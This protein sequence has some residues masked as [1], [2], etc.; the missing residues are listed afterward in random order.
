V[1]LEHFKDRNGLPSPFNINVFKWNNETVFT[2]NEGIFTYNTGKNRFEPHP[3]LTRTLG[4]QN[5]IRKLLEFRDM[6]WFVQDDE[7]GYFMTGSKDPVLT[8]GLFLQLKGTLNES[9]ECILPVNERNV[10]IGT[11]EGLFSFDLAYNPSG[12]DTRT[13]ITGVSQK[14]AFDETPLELNTSERYHRT[15][16]YQTTSVRFSFSAPGFDDKM[17]IQYSYLLEGISED[18]SAWQDV[19]FQEY[20]GLSPGRYVFRVKARSLLGEK[21]EEAA[22][23]FELIPV[24]YKTNL[25]YLG[26]TLVSLLL[27]VMVVRQI[28]RR[29]E[30]VKKKTIAEEEEKRKVLQLEIEHIKLEREKEEIIKDKEILE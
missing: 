21:A 18:W 20:T 26:Y 12:N 11:R 27:V 9:M 5:N 1:G 29:I 8:K 15:L 30:Y 17:N 3:F 16:P 22:Y 4:V 19:P 13:V 24:W 14:K 10:L 25:A 7:V 6:T 2:T 23:H 28:Q